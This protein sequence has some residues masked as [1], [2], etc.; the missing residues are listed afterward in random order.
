[1][2]NLLLSIPSPEIIHAINNASCSYTRL[3]KI[4]FNCN[5]DFC[6]EHSVQQKRYFTLM[7][8]ACSQNVTHNISIKLAPA[9]TIR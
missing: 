6:F 7:M 2:Q 1:M 8:F 4:I 3:S 5:R 9:I